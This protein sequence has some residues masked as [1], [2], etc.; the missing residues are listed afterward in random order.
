MSCYNFLGFFRREYDFN[1]FIKGYRNFFLE[2]SKN[3]IFIF[4]NFILEPEK[5]N[6][7]EKKD[8]SM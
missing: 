2:A 1:F 8:Y 6:S 5:N 7:L 4:E 3:N